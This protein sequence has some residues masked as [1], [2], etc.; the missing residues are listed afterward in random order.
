[1]MNN[2]EWNRFVEWANSNRQVGDWAEHNGRTVDIVS[3][4]GGSYW[5]TDNND[6][7]AGLVQTPLQA[8][9]FLLTG[10]VL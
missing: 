4:E 10:E 7:F 3:M 6:E 1:M 2:K 5:C 9:W 8:A